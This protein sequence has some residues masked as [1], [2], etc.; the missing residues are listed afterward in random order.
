MLRESPGR[1]RRALVAHP[2]SE[3]YGSDRVALESVAALVGTGRTVHTTLTSDGPLR[4]HLEKAGS[5][6]SV[7]AVPVLRKSQ[8]SVGGL[9]GLAVDTVR[10]TPGM[11]G[12]LWRNRPHLV[13]VST[14]TVPW[15]LV[16]ARLSGARVV[17]HVHEA[18]ES[19]PR[20]VRMGLAAPLLLAH[21]VIANSELSRDVIVRDLPV[22]RGR[23]RVVYNGVPGPDE[24]TPPRS[25]LTGPVRLVL[26]GRLSPR[27]GTDVA[28]EALALLADRGVDAVL[29]LVGGVFPGYEWFE[30]EVRAAAERTGVS[31]RVRWRGVQSDV[32][33]ALAGA[34]IVLVP[35]R[36]EPFGNAAV[37][38]MLAARPVVVGDTQGLRE[39][40]RHGENG[41]LAAPDDPEALA[42]AIAAVVLDWPSAVH[43]AE[44]ARSE[45]HQRFAPRRYRDALIAEL[46]DHGA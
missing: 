33:D 40:V 36:V 41:F 43:R 16:L 7:L 8:M 38:A 13:Y 17:C 28:V 10:R 14:V 6:V 24:V 9:L 35:S 44:H 19:V 1:A 20:I 26:V 3:L 32:W 23:T 12:M 29:D 39:I 15:W 31:H 42:D 11:L 27:K 30:Q 34:D 37:E 18:E 5:A 2:S 21:R 46:Y 45:A 4:A 22:L 25:E